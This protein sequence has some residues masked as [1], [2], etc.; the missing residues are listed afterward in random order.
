[1]IILPVRKCM[2]IKTGRSMIVKGKQK[3]EKLELSF[4]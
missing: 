3:M 4:L 2:S 1:M